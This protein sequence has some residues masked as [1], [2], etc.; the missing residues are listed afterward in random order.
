MA[1]RLLALKV[2]A[3]VFNNFLKVLGYIFS[4]VLNP[5]SYMRSFK[6]FL[7]NVVC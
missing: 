6:I 5:N 1:Y 4:H 3:V 7:L 2:T